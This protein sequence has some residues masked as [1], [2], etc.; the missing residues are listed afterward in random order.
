MFHEVL[1]IELVLR[2]HLHDLEAF[3]PQITINMNFGVPIV[4]LVFVAT[5]SGQTDHCAE[6]PVSR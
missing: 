5:S 6:C 3:I 4:G 1:R 2:G